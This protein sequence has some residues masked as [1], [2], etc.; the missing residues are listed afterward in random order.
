MLKKKKHLSYPMLIALG[1]F[2]MII[3]GALLLMLPISNKSGE[4]VPFVDAL[5][6]AT[7][8]SCV[9]G[10][11]VYDTFTQWTVFG[12]L[13]IIALIQTG[14]LGFMTI[15]TMF[16]LFL[17]RRI[18]LAER[19][20]MRE[21]INTMYIGGIIRLTKRILIGTLF[22]ET[23]GAILLSI[24]FV[25]LLGWGEGIWCGV[26]HSISAFCNAGF[27]LFGRF[28]E[29][30]SLTGFV[31][32]GLVNATI[33]SL[34]VIGGIGFFVWDDLLEHKFHFKAYRLHTKI[35]LVTTAILLVVP[36]ILFF[37]FERTNLLADLS[38]AGKFWASLF[39][40]VTPRT[41]GFN[42]IDTAALSP[43]SG[44]LTIMLM[45]IGG[46]PGSTAGG[47]KTATIAVIVIS[48]V[49]QIR[50]ETVNNVF[51]RRLEDGAFKRACAVFGV[52]FSLVLTAI[53]AICAAQPNLPLFDITFEC[54]SAIGTVGMS[55]GV[56][57]ALCNFSRLIVTFLM[58]AG[59]VG[60]LSFALIFTEH[61]EV[62]AVRMPV[63]RINI[64]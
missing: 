20:L 4:S 44:L 14:G 45:F 29:Y 57:R 36:T 22:F 15:I 50:N 24:R 56:T 51:G 52:N 10:L 16:S 59:R 23:V 33:I 43:A 25:P 21:S 28:G 26:F 11:V 40:A 12:Q 3:I 31:E 62:P 39:S 38:P 6:T 1:F 63:E 41:A 32:D 55:T 37:F 58:Y 53:L 7:S 5:F 49:A 17:R 2:I 61:R 34:I 19:S 54:F 9:T 42:T 64:G 30:I 48:L 60:S 47:I 13:V 27:D 35:V 8:A 46:S 18:G